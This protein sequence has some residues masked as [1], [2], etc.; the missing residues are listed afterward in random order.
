MKGDKRKGDR[1][2]TKVRA[3]RV[4]DDLW[5]AAQRK[6]KANGESVADVIRTALIKYTGLKGTTGV[7]GRRDR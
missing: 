7:V 1:S 3:I 2:A 6:A 5:E 4:S